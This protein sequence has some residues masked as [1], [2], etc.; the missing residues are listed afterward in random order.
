MATN[1]GKF[2]IAGVISRAQA[3]D[4]AK[5]LDTEM[6]TDPTKFVIP[7]GVDRTPALALA[8]EIDAG[9]N[10]SAEKLVNGFFAD[11][12]ARELTA[13]IRSGQ[14]N[15]DVLWQSGISRPLAE[16][17]VAAIEKRRTSE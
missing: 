12:T 15:A 10:C 3:V 13:Q 16:A 2:V 9:K 7:G 1:P 17:I 11:Y 5:E 8:R 4:I 6:A 14:G